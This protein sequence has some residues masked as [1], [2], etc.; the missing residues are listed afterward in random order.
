VFEQLVG[1][2]EGEPTRAEIIAEIDWVLDCAVEHMGAERAN[3]YL[4][5]FYPWYVERLGGGKALQGALQTAPTLA[6]ARELMEPARAAA[7]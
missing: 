2:R 4:R 6:D 5:K 3:R 7:A 1:L